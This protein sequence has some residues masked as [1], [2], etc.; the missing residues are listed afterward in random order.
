V[1]FDVDDLEKIPEVKQKRTPT[2]FR[3][4]CAIIDHVRGRLTGNKAFN[5]F[6]THIYQGR[7]ANDGFF[8]KKMGVVAGVADM[9]ILWRT[10][11]SCG[12]PKVG[13]GFLEC[14]TKT[15]KLSGVQGKF[16]GIC[17][18]LGIHYAEARSVKEAHDVLV[19]WGCHVNHAAIREPDLRSNTQKK[20]DGFDM[21]K[22]LG[23]A[24]KWGDRQ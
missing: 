5:V 21:Y 11:C 13:I 16:R 1:T 22:P 4:Q 18:W 7:D 17:H 12:L 10:S 20:S 9:L 19:G 6:I 15:G 2:E 23:S 8:L 24:A 3:L 14:K